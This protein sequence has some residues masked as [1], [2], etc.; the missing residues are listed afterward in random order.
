ML[1]LAIGVLL[2]LPW[3]KA[4]PRAPRNGRPVL[5]TAAIVAASLFVG[6]V[7]S[8]AP[9]VHIFKYHEGL[10]LDDVVAVDS[11]DLLVYAPVDW[12][13][14]HTPLRRPLFWWAP[15]WSEGDDFELA[16][17]YRVRPGA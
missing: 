1:L 6:Y 11:H 7:L 2:A 4:R 14:D 5:L 10:P 12:L 9:V 8:Y 16:W 13:I 3:W 17:W 15:A